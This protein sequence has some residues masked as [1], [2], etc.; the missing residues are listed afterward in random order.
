MFAGQ[1]FLMFAMSL[2]LTSDKLQTA[3]ALLSLSAIMWTAAFTVAA[4]VVTTTEDADR[5]QAL[6]A[7]GS[8]RSQLLVCRLPSCALFLARSIWQL[9]TLKPSELLH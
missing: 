9:E 5:G 8:W 7:L 2:P 3:V 6:E 1:M 4:F